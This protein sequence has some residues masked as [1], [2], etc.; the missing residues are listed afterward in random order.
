MCWRQELIYLREAR[1]G[2]HTPGTS[3]TSEPSSPPVRRA[4]R[5]GS[6]HECA[7]PCSA[8]HVV[9]T[10]QQG[11]ALAG[12][13]RRP[14]SRMAC[15]RPL[16]C[17]WGRGQQGHLPSPQP[18][19]GTWPCPA[20]PLQAPQACLRSE[21]ANMSSLMLSFLRKGNQR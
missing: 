3:P 17:G 20:A 13:P 14:A 5:P 18:G 7:V 1:V 21:G 10:S 11:L 6:P 16:Q 9:S 15:A 12:P 4:R 2:Q 8:W 19:P